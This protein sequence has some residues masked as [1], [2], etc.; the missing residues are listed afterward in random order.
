MPTSNVWLQIYKNK[1]TQKL[2]KPQIFQKVSFQKAEIYF[3]ICSQFFHYE[4]LLSIYISVIK[5]FVVKLLMVKYTY[6]IATCLPPHGVLHGVT[7]QIFLPLSIQR[8]PPLT[9][10]H[11]S[12]LL[13]FF[14]SRS[15][16]PWFPFIKSFN[17]FQIKIFQNMP[18]I[19]QHYDIMILQLKTFSNIL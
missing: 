16:F 11:V 9:K 12:S 5:Q 2:L 14:W 8:S 18:L 15:P 4:N 3:Q 1:K 7:P 6:L 13:K 19:L 17:F 10:K